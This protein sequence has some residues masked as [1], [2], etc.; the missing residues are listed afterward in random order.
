MQVFQSGA[1]EVVLPFCFGCNIAQAVHA[2]DVCGQFDS[3]AMLIGNYKI[4]LFLRRSMMGFR[5]YRTVQFRAFLSM[6]MALLFL[7]GLFSDKTQN[8]FME[9]CKV[10]TG[11]PV[12]RCECASSKIKEI[13]SPEH[14]KIMGLIFGS[15]RATADTEV[16]KLGVGGM[17]GL[18]GR[19]GAAA[20][21]A[22]RQCNIRGLE[23]M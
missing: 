7:F 6:G 16:A 5:I 8:S 2:L 19:W 4:W 18:M 17:F 10:A 12:D 11:E 20:S 14:W 23:R 1:I 13:L 15:D 3:F 9:R 21:V 22:E